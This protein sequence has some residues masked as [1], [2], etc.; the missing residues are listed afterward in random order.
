M[1]IRTTSLGDLKECQ[2]APL[3]I[4]RRRVILSLTLERSLGDILRDIYIKR[5]YPL[6]SLF[7]K[8]VVWVRE[9]AGAPYRAYLLVGWTYHL[10]FYELRNPPA[11]QVILGII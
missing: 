4:Y 9:A 5:Y 6:R 11:S 10:D 3:S 8:L 1:N 7:L 2:K